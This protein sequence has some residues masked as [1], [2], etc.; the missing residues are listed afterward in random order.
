MK[1]RQHVLI[2]LLNAGCVLMAYAAL[3]MT[4]ER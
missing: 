1:T 4:L 3:N 2:V